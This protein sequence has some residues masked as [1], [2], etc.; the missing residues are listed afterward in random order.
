RNAILKQGLLKW[1]RDQPMR[2]EQRTVYWVDFKLKKGRPRAYRNLVLYDD[3]V[4]KITGEVDCVH[5][6]LRFHRAITVKR[7]GIRSVRDLL[8]VNPK[9]LFDKHLKFTDI[10]ERYVDKRVREE[11]TRQR[12]NYKGKEV[13]SNTDHYHAHIPIKVKSHLHRLGLNRS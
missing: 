10:A 5:L 1:R 2:D 13:S 7:Q 6:E 8:K 9:R 4:N 12:K 3:K 11:T